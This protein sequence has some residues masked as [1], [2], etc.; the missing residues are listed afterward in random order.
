MAR[1]NQRVLGIVVA[2]QPSRDALT[3]LVETIALQL[4]ALLVVDNTPKG[5]EGAEAIFRMRAPP[6]NV[7]IQSLGQNLG[8]AV[9]Q[10]IG[11]RIALEGGYDYVLLSDQDSLP[12]HDMVQGLL[13]AMEQLQAQGVKAAAVGPTFTDRNT[14]ITFPFQAKV[15]GKFFYGHVRATEERPVVEALTLITSGKLIPVEALLDVGSMREDLFID[16]VDIE[17]C[18]RARARGWRVFGTC[19]GFMNHTMGDGDLDVWYFGWRKETNYSPVRI[20]YQVRNYVALCRDGGIELRWK[21]RNGWYTFGVVYSQVI[22]GK[23]GLKALRM[24]FRGFW[25]GLRD[26]MGK[27]VPS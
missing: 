16:K 22:F 19:L 11:I 18:L 8:I 12:D 4:D 25:D 20:Y 21:V 7:Q 3:S 2:F 9:A 17:W 15:P 5:S 6:S 23:Y 13:C 14:G 1:A 10:N 27:Y 26:R 24:A